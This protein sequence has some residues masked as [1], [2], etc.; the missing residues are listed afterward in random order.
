MV[1]PPV[2][3]RPEELEHPI[4][5]RGRVVY[6]RG[7]IIRVLEVISGLAGIVAVVALILS[8]TVQ[9]N[10]ISDIQ[11]ERNKAARDT[12][13]LLQQLILSSGHITHR[14]AQAQ[15]YLVQNGLSNCVAYAHRVTST[16]GG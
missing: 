5:L 16:P 7:P 11:R 12:C 9:S 4:V 1:V 3:P 10:T 2:P 6:S 8:L 15:K 14:E 13:D